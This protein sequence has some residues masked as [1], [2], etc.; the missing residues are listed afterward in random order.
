MAKIIKNT[1]IIPRASSVA[2]WDGIAKA[3]TWREKIIRR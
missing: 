1:P 3:I 2:R